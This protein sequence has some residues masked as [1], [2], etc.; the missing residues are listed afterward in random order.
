MLASH[1]S[2]V[3]ETN[4][5]KPLCPTLQTVAAINVLAPAIS[6]IIGSSP[7]EARLDVRDVRQQL[8][9]HIQL[10]SKVRANHFANL[11]AR[12]P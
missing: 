10:L 11:R 6:E 8:P 2:P 4:T 7:R 5:Y 9:D 12:V 3:L 1:Q